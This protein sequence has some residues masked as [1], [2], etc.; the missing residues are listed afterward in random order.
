M[1]EEEWENL[2]KHI[3]DKVQELDM[4]YYE[5]NIIRQAMDSNN[6]KE[7]VVK[8]LDLFINVFA[9]KQNNISTKMMKKFQENVETEDGN[10][11]SDVIL[12]FMDEDKEVFRQNSDSI[13]ILEFGKTQLEILLEELA[14]LLDEFRSMDNDPGFDPNFTPRVM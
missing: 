5:S 2:F 14:V 7:K 11:I 10:P 9:Y 12:N 4:G 3:R 6:A 13:S 8:Y 1:I